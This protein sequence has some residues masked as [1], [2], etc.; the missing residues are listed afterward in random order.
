MEFDL[1]SGG[2]IYKRRVKSVKA[3]NLIK[4]FLPLVVRV[5]DIWGIR[6]SR[7]SAS[8]LRLWR[9]QKKRSASWHFRFLWVDNS[10]KLEIWFRE[11]KAIRHRDVHFFVLFVSLCVKMSWFMTRPFN[12]PFIQII[13]CVHEISEQAS[14]VG[15]R[16]RSKTYKRPKPKAAKKT[17][18]IIIAWEAR[19]E[20]YSSDSL[21]KRDRA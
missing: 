17:I 16:R 20:K 10:S 7:Q 3:G 9:Q 15:D 18:W 1:D 13:L 6:H 12:I 2:A 14:G 4:Y 11:K 21:I 19:R 8:S 5:F